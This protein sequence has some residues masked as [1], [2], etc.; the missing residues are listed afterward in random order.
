M[1]R[2]FFSCS[3]I[4]VAICLSLMLSVGYVFAQW[5]PAQSQQPQYPPQQP[6][7]P[8]QQ[9]G[10][11]PQ[12]PG[13]PQQQP[14]YPQQQPGYPQQPQYPPQAAGGTTFSDAFGRFKVNLPQGTMPMGATY[15]FG[16]PSAMCQVS[17]MV[18]GQDQMFQ[19]QMQNFP[20]MLRQMGGNVESE[21]QM[22][23]G[24]KQA[25]VISASIRDQMSGSSMRSIN[26]FIQGANL[27]V[28]VMGPD[29][30]SQQIQQV[31]QS[32]LGGLQF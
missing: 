3:L 22:D 8:Q 11:P 5:P 27:W 20:N 28:Q 30:N 29:Q 14:G 7:Y 2:R 6:G 10:Y 23:V 25:R 18:V 21:N 4:L 16:I 12:Q 19:M 15:N 31:L 26:V 1:S 32:V 9:P 17:I 24:G 13:Y